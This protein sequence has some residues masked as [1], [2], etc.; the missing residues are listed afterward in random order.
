M[1]K[2]LKIE[3]HNEV[4][5]PAEDSYLMAENSGASKDDIVLDVGTGSGI[6]ALT[7]AQHAKKVLAV[8]INPHALETAK[9]NAK[10]NKIKNIEFRES[11]LFEKIKPEEKFDL[12]IFN[13][14]YVPSDEK[15]ML[16]KAWAGGKKGREVIDRFIDSAPEHLNTGGRIT[17][18]I[19]SVNEPEE[20][21]KKLEEKK[22]T[23]TIT[24][25]KK[26]FFEE[27]MILKAEKKQ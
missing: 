24:A 5:N 14:P 6:Q 12:I 22:L 1:E 21:I 13:P 4:Y 17:L 27:L 19:S 25:K 18:L 8:D 2:E 9:K 26:L 11:N 20:V 3:T 15:Y 16:G 23:V 7:A 10:I